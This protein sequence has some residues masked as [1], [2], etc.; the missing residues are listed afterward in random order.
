M[1]DVITAHR[2]SLAAAL[3]TLTADQWRGPSLCAGWT[4]VHVLAHLTM[5][6]RITEADFMA[7]LQR[8][9]GDFTT[10]SDEI[11]ARDSKL[12]PAELVDVLRQNADNPWAPRGGSLTNALSHD[13]IHG[14]DITWPLAVHQEIPAPAMTIVLTSITSPLAPDAG[15]ARAA[16][17]SAAEK[18][19]EAGHT[20]LFGFPLS[21]IRVRATDLDWSAGDG[22]ELAGRSRDLLPLLANRLVPRELFHGPGVARAWTLADR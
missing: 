21:G 17:I 19:A 13:V 10:F 11:V 9:G 7:G 1:M 16:E 8:R 5:P 20:T 14:L 22:E 15:G 18:G 2:R 4:P 12:P 3:S 6:F